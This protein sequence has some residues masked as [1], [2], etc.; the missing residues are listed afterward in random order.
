MLKC[1]NIFFLNHHPAKLWKTE[2]INL[3]LLRLYI[4]YFLIN[5]SLLNFNL[6]SMHFINFNQLWEEFMGFP[7][8]MHTHTDTHTHIHT[9][10][11]FKWHSLGTYWKLFINRLWAEIFHFTTHSSLGSHLYN[12]QNYLYLSTHCQIR[13]K[14]STSKTLMQVFLHL[15]FTFSHYCDAPESFYQ[16]QFFFPFRLKI[17]TDYIE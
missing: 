5:I 16:V 13:K 6:F 2:F 17:V 1:L 8:C 7:C 14:Y 11:L 10:Y 3:P 4:W 9:K 12:M 15:S